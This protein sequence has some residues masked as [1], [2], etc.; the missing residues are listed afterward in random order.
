MVENLPEALLSSVAGVAPSYLSRVFPRP[1]TDTERGVAPRVLELAEVRELD[2]LRAQLD[3][4]VA[5]EPCPCG[6][7]SIGMSVDV[8][9]AQRTSYSGRPVAEAYYESGA[10]MVWVDDGLLS[11]LEVW[12]WSDEA[13]TE[14]PSPADLHATPPDL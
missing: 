10:V 8:D 7:P 3:V 1:L 6:C 2:R 9:E 12:W 5:S 13:P 14:W 4:A 11:N